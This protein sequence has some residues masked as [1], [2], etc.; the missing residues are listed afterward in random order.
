MLHFGIRRC[1]RTSLALVV[2][3]SAL[4]A[5]CTE[6]L[7]RTFDTTPDPE[8]QRPGV[9]PNINGA[10]AAPP[11]KLM[12]PEELAKE[13]AALKAKGARNNPKIA[14]DAIKASAASS[15]A[16]NHAAAAGNADAAKSG[17]KPAITTCVDS[18]ATKCPH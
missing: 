5:G 16:L 14:A 2:A 3:L 17:G 7:H 12:T 6:Q 10:V 18:D 1:H 15:K 11:G 4:S 8:L 13:T 9:Y